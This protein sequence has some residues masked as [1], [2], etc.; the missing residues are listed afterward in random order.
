MENQP[1]N[2]EEKRIFYV[3]LSRAKTKFIATYPSQHVAGQSVYQRN[4]SP[5]LA[6]LPKCAVE[7]KCTY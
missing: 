3:A 6:R 1:E 2:T 4:P 5:Y 7:N